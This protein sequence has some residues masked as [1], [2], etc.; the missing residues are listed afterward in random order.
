MFSASLGIF[1]ALSG[2]RQVNVERISQRSLSKADAKSPQA[3]QILA[4]ED[5]PNIVAKTRQ[6][7]CCKVVEAFLDNQ[8]I[9]LEGCSSSGD[10]G[11]ISNTRPCKAADSRAGSRK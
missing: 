1:Y 10:H 3:R 11:A 2:V 7:V 5:L 9:N 4:R 6:P 8:E